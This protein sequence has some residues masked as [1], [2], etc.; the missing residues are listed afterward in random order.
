M[1]WTK[2][3]EK[4]IT[5]PVSNLLVTAAAGAGK[6]QVLS[7]RILRRVQEGVD[8]DRILVITFTRAAAAE[9]KERIGRQLEE[10]A[11]KAGENQHLAPADDAFAKRADYHH[12]RLLQGRCKRL[13][14]PDWH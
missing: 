10:A 11:A 12:P 6:T 13:F 14:L 4:A 2:D 3:Q 5:A 9:M 1:R 8:I 7:G